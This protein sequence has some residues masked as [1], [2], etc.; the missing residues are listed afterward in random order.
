MSTNLKIVPA[1]NWHSTHEKNS[2]HTAE[3]I[4][5]SDL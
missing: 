2:R 5:L 4:N 3:K 1:T